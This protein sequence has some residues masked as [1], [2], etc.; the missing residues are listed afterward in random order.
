[1]K[2]RLLK[3]LNRRYLLVAL[4]VCVALAVVILIVLT[5]GIYPIVIVNYI[6]PIMAYQLDKGLDITI[7]FYGIND[8]VSEKEFKRAVLEE[9]IDGISIDAELSKDMSAS[10]VNQKISSQIDQMLSDTNIQNSLSAKGISINDAKKYFLETAIKSQLV[11]SQLQLEGK[12]FSQWLVEQR[13]GLKIFILMLH[14]HWTGQE[15]TFD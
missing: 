2:S 13:K 1:M 6:H 7:K 4:Y 8:P 3:I 10:D 9:L 14:T 15:I 5:F 11:V 12:N